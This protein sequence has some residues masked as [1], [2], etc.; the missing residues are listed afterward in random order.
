M[1]PDKVFDWNR[2]TYLQRFFDNLIANEDRN[3]GEILITKD[4]R[5][6][7]IDHSRTFRTWKKLIFAPNGP[8][9]PKLMSSLPRA[10]FEK[11]KALTFESI[12]AAVGDYLTGE[13]IRTM[14]VR[15]D[16]ILKEIEALIKLNGE[17]RTLYEK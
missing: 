3:M 1:P 17:A 7:L 15:R 4:W 8:E 2:A 10:V 12:K 13:E 14:L 16:L 9:G 6:I 5:M 11:A